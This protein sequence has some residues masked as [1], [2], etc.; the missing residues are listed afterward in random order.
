[1]MGRKGI[2]AVFFAIFTSTPAAAQLQQDATN[3]APFGAPVADKGTF[4]HAFLEEFEGR[5]GAEN[6]FRWQGEAWW[7]TDSDRLWVKSEGETNGA[8]NVVDGQHE[9]LYDR[10][11][12]S[13]FDLQ[14]GLRVDADSHTGRKWA[15]LGVE[16]LA[17]LF[18]H[19]SATGYASDEG[20]FAAKLEGDYDL[21]LTQRLILQPQ[22]ET[23]FYA[24]SDPGRR[25]GSGLADLDTG[26]RLRYEFSRKFAPYVAATYE[27][28]F[29]STATFTRADGERTSELRFTAGIRM[30]L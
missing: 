17:P 13:F 6:S 11:I 2:L 14:A 12:T 26:L 20:H 10:P 28:S 9:I 5:F 16:G 22:I 27:D 25:L 18:L 24:K 8:G 3:P 19:V 23:N 29:G 21:L 30:W 7:G 4:M 1:M 15:A